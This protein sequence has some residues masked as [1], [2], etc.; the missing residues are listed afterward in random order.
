MAQVGNEGMY[1][2]WMLEESD[3]IQAAARA[4]ADKLIAERFQLAVAEADADLKPI[5]NRIFSLFLA[6]TIEDRATELLL[7]GII[8]S[9][10]ARNLSSCKTT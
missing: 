10:E 3:L 9:D 1:Q 2:T 8:T 6:S 5:L 4:F 7:S